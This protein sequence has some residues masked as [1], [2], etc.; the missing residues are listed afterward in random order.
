MQLSVFAVCV[1]FATATL[2][3]PTPAFRRASCDITK[4]F[5][6]LAPTGLTCAAAAAQEVANPISDAS[7]LVAAAKLGVEFPSSCTACIDEFDVGD[8]V[9]EAEDAVGDGIDAIGDGIS[10][11][12]G[13][14]GSIF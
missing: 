3:A 7:C 8:A 4:C 11:V 6:D 5:L 9:S 12:A 14:I 1:A 13:K 10:N 2:A